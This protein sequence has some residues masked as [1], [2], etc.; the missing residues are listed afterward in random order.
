[1]LYVNPISNRLYI[2]KWKNISI[3]Y[4]NFKYVCLNCFL[5]RQTDKGK[6]NGNL[7]EEV[8]TKEENVVKT[9]YA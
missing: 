6:R 4:H 5:W 3:I 2:N 8:D 1:M 7:V 9:L